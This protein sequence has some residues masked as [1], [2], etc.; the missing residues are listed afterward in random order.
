MDLKSA[1]GAPDLV[2]RPVLFL[3][4]QKHLEAL[5]QS[6]T[7]ARSGGLHG[8]LSPPNL[9]KVPSEKRREVLV[10]MKENQRD[11]LLLGFHR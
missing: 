5:K 11:A 10:G 3:Q 4:Q 2:S 6:S 1:F 8:A 7:S 9:T